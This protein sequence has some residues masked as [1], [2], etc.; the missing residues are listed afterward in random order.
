MKD[1]DPIHYW[2][3]ILVSDDHLAA[4]YQDVGWY[5][6]T[7]TWAHVIGPFK[8]KEEADVAKFQYAEIL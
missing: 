4:G 5:F 6:W 1:V 3:A 8:S 7:E 2:D